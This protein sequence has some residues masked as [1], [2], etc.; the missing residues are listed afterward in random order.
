LGRPLGGAGPRLPRGAREGGEQRVNA[1]ARTLLAPQ[2]ALLVR[3]SV[4]VSRVRV[5]VRRVSVRVRVS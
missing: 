4:R 1:A 3:V 2:S 5:R